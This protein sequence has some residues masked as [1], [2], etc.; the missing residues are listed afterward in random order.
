VV[1]SVELDFSFAPWYFQ[2]GPNSSSLLENSNFRLEMPFEIFFEENP[3]GLL[4]VG[5]QLE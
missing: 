4:E 3:L 2:W 5:R 1:V